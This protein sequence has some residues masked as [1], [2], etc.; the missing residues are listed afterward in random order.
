MKKYYI[1][2]G[3]FA[4]VYTLFWAD[5]P[6]M[7]KLLP[8]GA[9]RISRKEAERLA[10]A[11]NYRRKH[12]PSSSGCADCAIYPAGTHWDF[13]PEGDPRYKKN[14]YIWERIK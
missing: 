6:E 10:A 2:R 13:S 14:G 1:V 12:T 4:N 11:E 9:E 7:E 5:G 8:E 3:N